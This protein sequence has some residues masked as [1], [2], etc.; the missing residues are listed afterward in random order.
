MDEGHLFQQRNITN[1]PQFLNE[2][3]EMMFYFQDKFYKS[4]ETEVFNS[5][6]GKFKLEVHYYNHEEELRRYN[7]TKGIIKNN[8]ESVIDIIYRN[9]SHFPYSWVEVDGNE[10]LLCGL[11]YQGYSIVDLS[12][13]ETK[14]YVSVEAYA[15]HGFCWAEIFYFQQKKL[16][17]VDGCYWAA[18]YELV[19]YDF[20]KP[21]D[22][23]YIELFRVEVD[24]ITNW[25]KWKTTYE[26]KY[27]DQENNEKVYVF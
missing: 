27:I 5:P 19:F 14:H 6:S 10:Y 26:V 4:D 23:P 17:V 18:P 15:G 3:A 2:R 13:K 7:Y 24:Q 12:K 20:S 16:I 22:L 25:D 1:D 8:A 21:M 11:D 9:F